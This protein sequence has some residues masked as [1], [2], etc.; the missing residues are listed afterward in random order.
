[1][2]RGVSLA[3]L[4]L[5]LFCGQALA[6]EKG[7]YYLDLEEALCPDGVLSD[8]YA[9]GDGLHLSKEGY[10]AWLEY[11]ITHAAYDPSNPYVGGIDPGP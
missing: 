5:T 3:L 2:F 11:L 1:M 8:A 7:C 9:S 10:M 6:A 4:V